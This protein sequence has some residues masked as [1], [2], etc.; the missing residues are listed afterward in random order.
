MK[1]SVKI[2]L[3]IVITFLILM[4]SGP[5][6]IKLSSIIDFLPSSFFNQFVFFVFS[7]ILII[8]FNKKRVIEFNIKQISIKQI[9]PPILIVT[10]FVTFCILIS[11][12]LFGSSNTHQGNMPTMT[13]TEQFFVIVIFASISEE[14]LFRGFLQ[15][16]LAPIQT[17]GIKL[18]KIK[19]SLPVIISG[20]FFGIIHFAILTFGASFVFALTIVLSAIVMGIIA[21]YY[22]EK[23]NN[24]LF[25]PIIHMT[26][27]LIG[28]ILPMI[29]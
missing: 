22:Q 5:I 24:F 14:L 18:F 16:M 26:A 17:I 8:I 9:V 3:G 11:E 12:Q 10:I 29:I 13:I 20:T 27:N 4:L 23:N 7:S 2:I 19:L 25:A 1:K 21:G 15:N 28:M 6:T